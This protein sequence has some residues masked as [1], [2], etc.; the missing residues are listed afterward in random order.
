MAKRKSRT[1]RIPVC[2]VPASRARISRWGAYYGKRYSNFRQQMDDTLPLV[3]GSRWR[4]VTGP[5]WVDVCFY[6]TRPAKPTKPFPIG[7]IDNYEKALYDSCN[8]IVWEDDTQ[9]VWTEAKKCY[10]PAK[11]T[12]FIELTIYY[13]D[14]SLALVN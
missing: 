5:I 2:P 8:G 11:E 1:W 3:V 14:D 13:G 7:D 12:G 6:C 10:A 9:I 4:P